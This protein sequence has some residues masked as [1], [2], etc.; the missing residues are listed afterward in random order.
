MILILPDL[1]IAMARRKRSQLKRNLED[2]RGTIL[3]HG[4]R[5][6]ATYTIV[7]AHFDFNNNPEVL[8]L[9]CSTLG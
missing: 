8:E 4:K 7:S 9:T 1:I 3:G 5:S 6:P 2:E